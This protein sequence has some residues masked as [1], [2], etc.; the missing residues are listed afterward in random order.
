MDPLREMLWR[1]LRFRLLTSGI[2]YSVGGLAMMAY[3]WV[4]W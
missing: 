3:I 2:I 1:D 4:N